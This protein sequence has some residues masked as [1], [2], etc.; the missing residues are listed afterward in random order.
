[1]NS[2]KRK[3]TKET[4]S[5][6]LTEEEKTVLKKV[7]EAT[8]GMNSRL[9]RDYASKCEQIGITLTEVN[10]LL[11]LCTLDEFNYYKGIMSYRLTEPAYEARKCNNILEK[12]GSDNRLFNAHS[13]PTQID[14]TR[15]MIVFLGEKIDKLSNTLGDLRK[16]VDE[17]LYAP[18]GPRAIQC[19]LSFQAAQCA[20]TDLNFYSSVGNKRVAEEEPEDDIPST[21]Y[22]KLDE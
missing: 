20:R 8:D 21:K 6:G 15:D 2:N 13:L 22:Q 17:L 9:I 19:S 7:C 5:S 11:T 16:D 10:R 12:I 18:G 1:M 4:Y 14:V 3:L